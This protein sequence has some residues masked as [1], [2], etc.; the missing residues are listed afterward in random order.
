MVSP[1]LCAVW[2]EGASVTACLLSQI[3]AGRGRTGLAAL[4]SRYDGTPEPLL[5]ALERLNCR[6]LVVALPETACALD[7]RADT[8]VLLSCGMGEAAERLM[9]G[10]DRMVV[11]LDDPDGVP[12]RDGPVPVWTISERR[13]EADLTARN[14]RLLPYRTE[15]EAVSGT[16]ICRL[17]VP[18]PEGLGLYPGLAAAAAALSFGVTLEESARRLHRAEPVPVGMISLP[19]CSPFAAA[20]YFDADGGAGYNKENMKGFP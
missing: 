17:S 10:C 14:L 20:G 3:L 2:G 6:S 12:E 11:N 5:R 18:L 19:R 7:R 9:H 16:D 13:D 4:T 8:A 1:R 15:F